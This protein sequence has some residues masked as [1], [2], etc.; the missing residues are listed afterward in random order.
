MIYVSI[1]TRKYYVR[2]AMSGWYRGFLYMTPL[3]QSMKLFTIWEE[4]L[5]SIYAFG[6]A[7]YAV[8]G[9]TAIAV[10]VQLALGLARFAGVG[11]ALKEVLDGA[12]QNASEP[13]TGAA[14]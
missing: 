6:S 14:C 11:K 13:A 4:Y 8:L 7:D 1:R 12:V 10:A 3:L 9:M 5:K 2:D